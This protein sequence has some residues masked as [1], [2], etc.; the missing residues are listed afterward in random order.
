VK[1]KTDTYLELALVTD[2]CEKAFHSTGDVL[3]A[4][5]AYF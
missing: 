1:L 4:V 3:L 5:A 2:R